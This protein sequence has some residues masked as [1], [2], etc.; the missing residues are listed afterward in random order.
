VAGVRARTPDGP[1]E[2]RADLVVGADGRHSVVR[3]RAGLAV[4]DLGAPMDVLWFRLPRK[5]GDPDQ[6]MGRFG[7]GQ[8]LAMLNRGEYWQC[9][10]VIAKGSLERLRRRGLP[11]FREAV[12]ELAPFARDR[13]G[14][15]R[16]WDEVKLLTV[17]VDRLARWYRPGLLCLG[18]AAHAMSPVG[19][20]G[21][22]LAVQDAVAA[23][24]ILAGP[25]REGRLT[26]GHLRRVQRRREL[27]TRVTQ[28]LQLLVQ[29]R[30]IA[31]VLGGTGALSPPL[32]LRLLAHFPSLQRLPARLIGIGVRPEHVAPAAG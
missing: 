17:R 2:V 21:I 15:L 25:L 4:R 19:G 32:A 12:A 28:W 24:N 26:S 10:Y 27:P 11:A 22:N 6:P 30:V 1:L 23:A 3:Q 20:V 18:D 16:G 7:L 8:L 9:G 5:P 13:V 31:R 14:E 29:E